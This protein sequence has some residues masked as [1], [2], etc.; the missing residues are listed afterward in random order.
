M[1]NERKKEYI[2][3]MLKA[4]HCQEITLK[5]LDEAWFEYR[6]WWGDDFAKELIS[7]GSYEKWKRKFT[8]R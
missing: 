3:L 1:I 6:T 2:K 8:V 5:E 4:I 7:Y